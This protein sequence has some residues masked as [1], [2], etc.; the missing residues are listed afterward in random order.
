MSEGKERL[1]DATRRRDAAHAP[2]LVETD[3]PSPLAELALEERT[4]RENLTTQRQDALDRQARMAGWL[5]LFG[6]GPAAV[7]AI[8]LAMVAGRPDLIW[9]FVGLGVGVQLYRIWKEQRRIKQIERE[10]ADPIDGS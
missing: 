3:G 9:P 2:D 5:M 4:A 10:L 8:L 6:V 1:A 7:A